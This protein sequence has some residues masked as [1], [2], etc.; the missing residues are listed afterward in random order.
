M[1]NCFML[2]YSAT[3]SG[4]WLTK[5]KLFILSTRLFQFRSSREIKRRLNLGKAW[6]HNLEDIRL[7][8]LKYFFCVDVKRNVA[9]WKNRE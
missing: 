9:H 2:S 1:Q 8:E 5:F 4:S 7:E 3:S 6:R